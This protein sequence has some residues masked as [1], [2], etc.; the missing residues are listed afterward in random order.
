MYKF[1]R[2]PY[3]LL[4]VF[5]HDFIMHIDFTDIAASNTAT[6]DVTN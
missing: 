3:F 6:D 4:F 5:G 1:N 2:F